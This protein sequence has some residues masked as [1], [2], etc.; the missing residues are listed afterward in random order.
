M[1]ELY[2]ATG[3]SEKFQIAEA[4]FLDFGIQ[5]IQAKLDIDEI[6]GEDSE[7][8]SIDKANKAFALLKKPV[9]INDDSWSIPGLKGFPGPYMKSMNHWLSPQDL[10]NLTQG[11]KDRRAIVIQYIVY[12]DS[13]TVKVIRNDFENSLLKEAR[14]NYGN[15]IQKIVSVPNDG[16]L[17]IAEAY[18]RGTTANERE[19]AAGWQQAA[20][21]YSNYQGNN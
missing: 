3:N 18:D 4:I 12:K 21:W 19:V 17:S 16:G 15:A 6:Q 7:V 8:I 5:L 11:L 9:V 13:R 10:L 1:S 2:F 14:G 20:Q